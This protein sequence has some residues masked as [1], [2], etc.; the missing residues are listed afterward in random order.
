MAT[1]RLLPGGVLLDTVRHS[2]AASGSPRQ[3]LQQVPF[4]V[5]INIRPQCVI[6]TCRA[7]VHASPVREVALQ[8]MVEGCCVM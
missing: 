2:A 7:R 5:C 3:H 8:A 4:A 6:F 1:P